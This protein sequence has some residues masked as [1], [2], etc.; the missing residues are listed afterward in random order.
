MDEKL[1]VKIVEMLRQ[2]MKKR[3]EAEKKKIMEEAKRKNKNS[4][5]KKQINPNLQYKIS[6]E[7]SPIAKDDALTAQTAIMKSAF[8]NTNEEYIEPDGK[9]V[10]LLSSDVCNSADA[11]EL[12]AFHHSYQKS[13]MNE[14]INTSQL[15]SVA[16]H[17]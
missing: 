8:G 3:Y 1:Q 7:N 9:E 13:I 15:M 11:C 12:N 16:E 10:L 4:I 6:S 14:H 17:E 2:K 5:Q